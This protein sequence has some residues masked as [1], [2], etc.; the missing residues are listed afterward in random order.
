MYL[1]Y[2]RESK[3]LDVSMVLSVTIK[4]GVEGEFLERMPPKTHFGVDGKNSPMTPQ[5]V[6]SK[7]NFLL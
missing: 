6:V 3:S 5:S 2:Q 7:V 1:G 4:C